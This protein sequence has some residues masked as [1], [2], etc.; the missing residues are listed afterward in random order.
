VEPRSVAASA[1]L[2]GGSVR[3]AKPVYVCRAAR[4][5]V[6]HEHHTLGI[7]SALN[8][9]KP[10]REPRI[11]PI[12]IR[13]DVH[14]ARQWQELN[15]L[16]AGKIELQAEYVWVDHHPDCV[17]TRSPLRK[18]CAGGSTPTTSSAREWTTCLR[19][20]HGDC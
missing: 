7:D 20:G 15:R 14:Y 8:G 19:A 11:G 9:K 13:L 12:A 2:A 17:R 18:I 3:A 4:N 1:Q 10:I 16:C 6:S 5:R